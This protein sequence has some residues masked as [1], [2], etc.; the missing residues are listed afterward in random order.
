MATH[1]KTQ[2]VPTDRLRLHPDNPRRGDVAAIQESLRLHGQF[3]PIVVNRA[4]REV[5]VGNHTLIA[6]RELGFSEIAVVFVEVDDEQAKRILV[7]DNRTSDLAGY[8]P[9][10]LA[11][12][13]HRSPRRCRVA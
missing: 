2:Y 12:L 11:E 8:D 6:A 9:E 4:T 13:L 5:L 7:V 10:A 1:L 3:K